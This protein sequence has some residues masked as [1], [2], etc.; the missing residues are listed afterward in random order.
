MYFIVIVTNKSISLVALKNYKKSKLNNPTCIHEKYQLHKF[1]HLKQLCGKVCFLS[2]NPLFIALACAACWQ[3]IGTD[4][5]KKSLNPPAELRSK[6]ATRLQSA[7]QEGWHSSGLPEA[8]GAMQFCL[9][10]A[11]DSW[12][13][14]GQYLGYLNH[15]EPA[16]HTALDRAA[17]GHQQFLRDVIF[18]KHSSLFLAFFT[19]SGPPCCRLPGS[20]SF[21]CSHSPL[22]CLFFYIVSTHY[23]VNRNMNQ[24]ES[25][26]GSTWIIYTSVAY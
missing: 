22:K 24:A 13:P 16:E 12:W 17:T 19:S 23:M 26:V 2:V 7:Q 14:P 18:P 21:T 25:R 8:E 6:W 15:T 11:S 10:K 5:C 9:E 3:K 20:G 4:G 1:F